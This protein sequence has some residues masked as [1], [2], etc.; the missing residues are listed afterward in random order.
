LTRRPRRGERRIAQG[1]A[2]GSNILLIVAMC[3]RVEACTE[4]VTDS[5]GR[6]QKPCRALP[7]SLRGGDAPQPFQAIRDAP[8]IRQF[9]VGP[10]GLF[11]ELARLLIVA[12]A[13]CYL[14]QV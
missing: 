10:Y 1:G 6:A 9:P 12:L 8:E 3:H 2:G 5:L 11:K 7:R 14:S 4:L 13:P